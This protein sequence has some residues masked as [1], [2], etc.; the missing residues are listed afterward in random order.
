[1]TIAVRKTERHLG[2]LR[3]D[4]DVS[5][6]GWFVLEGGLAAG[7]VTFVTSLVTFGLTA[8]GVPGLGVLT[9]STSLMIG[10]VVAVMATLVGVVAWLEVDRRG[11]AVRARSRAVLWRIAVGTASIGIAASGLLGSW[12]VWLMISSI[13]VVGALAAGLFA[14]WCIRRT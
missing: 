10:F 14:A 8:K 12:Q 9:A 5:H 3:Q 6:S 13:V 2:G 4:Q 7:I 11:L 1:M